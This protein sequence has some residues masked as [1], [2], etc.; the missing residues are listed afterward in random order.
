MITIEQK[1]SRAIASRRNY[2]FLLKVLSFEIKKCGN[3]TV[4]DYLN[5]MIKNTK[6]NVHNLD[7]EI[8]ELRSLIA[9][10]KEK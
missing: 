5:T 6:I 9:A 4:Q 10:L 3:K 8:P 1:L 7:R 2:K